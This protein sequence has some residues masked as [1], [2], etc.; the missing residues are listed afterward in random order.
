MPATLRLPVPGARRRYPCQV[1]QSF[2]ITGS[3]L[4][5]AARFSFAQTTVHHSSLSSRWVEDAFWSGLPLWTTGGTAL[6]VILVSYRCRTELRYGPWAA[7]RRRRY[8]RR[9]T[10]WTW[11]RWWRQGRC[12]EAHLLKARFSPW[13]FLMANVKR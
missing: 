12:A 11:R 7:S 10:S 1:R 13:P 4:P 6:Y 9:A 3:C 2:G 5:R 8:S